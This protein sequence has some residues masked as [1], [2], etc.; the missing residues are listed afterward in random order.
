MI[1]VPTSNVMIK[2]MTLCLFETVIFRAGENILDL[3]RRA[4][5]GAES[6]TLLASAMPNIHYNISDFGQDG[7]GHDHSP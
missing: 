1:F 5:Q 4:G 3:R 7:V 2:T 6:A